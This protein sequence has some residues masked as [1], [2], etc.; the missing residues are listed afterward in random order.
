MKG[1]QSE[2]KCKFSKKL[3][4]SF[5]D[6]TNQAGYKFKHFNILKDERIRQWLKFYSKW[7]TFPQIFID[8]EF[9]G[10]VDVVIDMI[11]GEEFDATVPADC[12]RGKPE[13]ELKQ[14]LA[15]NGKV[16]AFIEGSI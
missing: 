14:L 8:G 11:E 12:K 1:E 15:E 5:K 9:V 3:M 4:A 16:I 2:P 6:S 13:D 7:P 10:G